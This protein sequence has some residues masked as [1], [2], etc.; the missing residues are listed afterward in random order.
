MKKASLLLLASALCFWA[1]GPKEEPYNYKDKDITG[2]KVELPDAFSARK[3]FV[4]NEG[5]MGSNNASLDVLRVS[6]KQYI[7]GIW[8]KMNPDGPGLGDVANDIAVN[9]DEVWIVVNNSGYVEVISA[10]DETH[11][12]SITIPTPRSIAFDDNYAYVS[13]YSGAYITYGGDWSI[14]GSSNPKGHVYRIDKKT[15][16]IVGSA[17][18]VGY[19]PEGLAVW[20]G[21]LYV[22]NSGGFA[23]QL[24]PDYAYEKKV[25]VID[26]ENFKVEKSIEVAINLDK[27]YSDGQGNIF[28][29][30]MGDFYTTP[31]S[32][33]MISGDKV[34]KVADHA[35]KTC[36]LGDSVYVIGDDNENVYGDGITHKYDLSSYRVDNGSVVP[37]YIN[38]SFE[39]QPYGIAGVNGYLLLADAG[40]YFNPGTLSLYDTYNS[41]FKP[42]T[43]TAGVCPSHFAIW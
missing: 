2:V 32:L 26:L 23:S 21:K 1:C 39:G 27:V 10:L 41:S 5:Q 33:W 15:K 31:S 4:L 17:V 37:R 11:I 22:A 16:K 12:A 8:K 28:V 38:L 34:K 29:T 6:D 7:T 20:D 40:D 9:G 42:W 18:E 30:S 25:S 3:V 19:Q 24:P 35:Y 36:L 43:V 14:V 13:S